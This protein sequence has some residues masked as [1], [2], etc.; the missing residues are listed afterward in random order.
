MYCFDSSSVVWPARPHRVW[1][2]SFTMLHPCMPLMQHLLH[3]PYIE[4]CTCCTAVFLMTDLRFATLGLKYSESSNMS[5]FKIPEV[6]NPNWIFYE[7]VSKAIFLFYHFVQNEELPHL[8]KKCFLHIYNFP[9]SLILSIINNWVLPFYLYV[10]VINE[11][12]LNLFL[13]LSSLVTRLI[14]RHH[15]FQRRWVAIVHHMSS[16]MPASSVMQGYRWRNYLG[17]LQNLSLKNLCICWIMQRFHCF[18]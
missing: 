8:S 3:A 9:V 13:D 10:F 11:F 12:L 1:P 6:F 16:W 18:S 14:E 4:Q 17:S 2:K 7:V 5:N 15:C